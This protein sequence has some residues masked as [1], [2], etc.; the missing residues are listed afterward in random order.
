M[1]RFVRLKLH[2]PVAL[3]EKG[4]IISYS[5]KLSGTETRAALPHNNTPRTDL[6]PAENFDTQPL[7]I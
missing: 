3:G 2:N 5:D 6:L 4:K 7:G 1:N